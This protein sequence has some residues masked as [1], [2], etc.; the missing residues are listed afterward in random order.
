MLRL[1]G[2]GLL[3]MMDT[4]DRMSAMVFFLPHSKVRV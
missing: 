3:E 2:Q 1:V 4:Y